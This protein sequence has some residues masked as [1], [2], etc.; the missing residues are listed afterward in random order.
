MKLTTKSRY[1][2]RLL[3]DLAMNENK[4]PIPLKTVSTRQNISIKYLEQIILI[5]KKHEFV[6]TKRGIFGG[7][8]LA[9]PPEEIYIGDIVRVLEGI[10]AITDCTDSKKIK[11][12]VCDNSE[13]CLSRWVWAEASKAM[14]DKLDKIT[15]ADIINK[16]D[17]VEI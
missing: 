12:T 17:T 9:K 16:K 14:F 15:I 3:V 1:G 5:L 7:Y 2:T 13:D 11:S 4:K 8:L 10:S 6:K